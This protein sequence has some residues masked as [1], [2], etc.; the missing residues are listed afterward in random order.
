M[1][2]HDG[3]GGPLRVLRA[4]LQVESGRPHHAW[5]FHGPAGIGKRTTAMA[6]AARLL[7]VA[8][9][10]VSTH[11]DLHVVS[12]QTAE[13]H[14]EPR[15]R[16]QKQS[17]IPVEVLRD[18][19]ITP[20]ALGRHVV[21]D[22]PAGKVFIIDE[23][24]V[25][26][27]PGQNAL[28]K[29]LE[30]PPAGVVL[31]LVATSEDELL[32]TVR[33]R[34]RRLAFGELSEPQ[35]RAWLAR[36]GRSLAAEDVPD[37]LA[38]AGGSPGAAHL[39]L[40]HGLVSWPRTLGR[41]LA[42]AAGGGRVE[43]LGPAMTALVTA[44]AEHDIG[45]APEAGKERIKRV[46]AGRMLDFVARWARGQVRDACTRG[47]AARLE[48]ALRAVDAVGA[49]QAEIDANVRFGDALDNLALRVSAGGR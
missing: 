46:W 12:R 36:S 2:G 13:F 31:I 21:S 47:D 40:L 32:P 37:V 43:A 23:A 26:Q 19:V 30:E 5:V 6:F 9:A 10:R 1:I 39:A 41:H 48:R 24:E 44:S 45:E 11:P 18:F 17:T 33:S 29:T 27:A 22:S 38:F 15:I 20:A 8:A 28:L 4:A 3:P 14:S 16:A 7:G 49:A 34:C 42:S 35:M 25:M